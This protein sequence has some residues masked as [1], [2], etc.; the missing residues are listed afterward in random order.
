MK[1]TGF[2]IVRNGVKFDY[3]FIESI[4]SVLPLCDEM[5]VAVGNSEDETLTM[6]QEIDSPK[7]K[8]I[9]TIWDDSLREGGRVLAVETDK[10]KAAISEDTVWCIYIQADEVLHEK[11][12]P[13]IR[14]AMEENL[15]EKHIDG[16]LFDHLNLYG[17][18][19]YIAD[20]RK[21][22]Y[23][24]IRIIR[25]DPAITSFRDA[26]SFMKN[27]KRLKVKEIDAAV[28]H[29][30]WVR[31]PKAMQDK[32]ESFN[33]MWHD[34]E[35]MDKNFDKVDEFDFSNIDSLSKFE[36]THPKVMHERI[37]K[38]NWEFSFDPTQGIKLTPRL[39]FL[40]WLEKKYGI[41]IGKF[42]TYKVI[43]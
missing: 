40:N 17:S 1:V 8:I 15:N 23:K 10:A 21:W 30:G 19:D 14:K 5:I 16:I 28:Y 12:Y 22:A 31:H 25:N 13:T 3:P 39:R 27:G 11:D 20:S 18:F 33:K 43:S 41:E 32:M 35:W 38:M 34:D 9:Q 24:Q 37:D 36:G 29:Y 6:V 7:I 2:T 4:K 26:I 42:K